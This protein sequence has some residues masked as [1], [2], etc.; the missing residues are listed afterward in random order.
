MKIG[1]KVSVLD[2]DI[3]GVITA[4]LGDVVTILNEDGFEFQYTK[5]ELVIEND[6]FL[7]LHATP[8]NISEIIS[9]KQ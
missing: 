5:N 1:V 3:S 4:I 8:H 9:E 2:E 6:D 7:E